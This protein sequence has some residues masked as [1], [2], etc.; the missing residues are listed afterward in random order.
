MHEYA[1]GRGILTARA[2]QWAG[3]TSRRVTTIKAPNVM[4]LVASTSHRR[5]F[6]I[7]RRSARA[8]IITPRRL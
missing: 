5:T 4:G 1:C 2:D 3:M 7:G 6:R 8:A